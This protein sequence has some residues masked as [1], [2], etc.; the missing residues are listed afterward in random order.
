MFFVYDLPNQRKIHENSI[1]L[2]FTKIYTL[3][4]YANGDAM[5]LWTAECRNKL[6]TPRCFA[7][8]F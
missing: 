5:S 3:K 7:P 8:D 2:L 6:T 1:L 4:G